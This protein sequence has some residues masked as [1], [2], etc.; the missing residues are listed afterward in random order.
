MR[1]TRNGTDTTPGTCLYE[2][3]I[4]TADLVLRFPRDWLADWRT[5][6]AN[7]ERLIARLRPARG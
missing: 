4:D 3:R 2:R 6:A 7:F 5:V 1:C